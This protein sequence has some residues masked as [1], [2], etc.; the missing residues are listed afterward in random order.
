MSSAGKQ[1]HPL[2]SVLVMFTVPLLLGCLLAPWIYKLMP[3]L[4]DAIP[5]LA[6]RSAER[7]E[8][9]ASR[10]VQILALLM[11]WPCL[12]WSGATAVIA[13]GLR[14]PRQHRGRFIRGF[15]VAGLSIAAAYGLGLALGAYKPESE[16]YIATL[17][18]TLLGFL[19]TALA[20]GLLEEIFFRGFFQGS[21]RTRWP[22]WATALLTSVV[23]TSL[24]FFRPRVEPP[25]TD[26]GWL[27]GFALLPHLFAIFNP[28][29]DW[30]FAGTLFLMALALALYYEREGHL[31]HVAGLH[32]GWVFVLQSGDHLVDRVPDRLDLWFGQGDLISRAP[33]AVLV[34]FLFVLHAARPGL[35]KPAL[36][37]NKEGA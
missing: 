36:P 5:G 34:I 7:F 8:R 18:L 10:T 13:R 31:Y 30:Y 28:E 4:A 29:R 24:H 33:A 19:S 9:V 15:L 1:V 16:N 14:H 32:A 11:V 21:L 2:W 22:V 35:P 26:P 3:V 17:P 27:S 20:V 25:I 12:R 6:E 23:F 37:A